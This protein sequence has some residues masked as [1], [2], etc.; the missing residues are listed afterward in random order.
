M[1]NNNLQSTPNPFNDNEIGA[2]LEAQRGG[3]PVSTEAVTAPELITEP[4]SEP[5]AATE[6]AQVEITDE[7]GS[8]W[9]S[10]KTGGKFSKLEDIEIAE[11]NENSKELYAL[12]KEGKVDDVYDY[13][14]K[15]KEDYSKWDTADLLRAKLQKENPTLNKEEIEDIL[16][17]DYK[18]GYVLSEEDK[19]NMTP[20]EVEQ[21]E[22]ESKRSQLKAKADADG[23]R[24]QLEATKK[25]LSLPKITKIEPVID[26][27]P[28]AITEDQIKAAQ[29]DWEAEVEAEMP[30]SKDISFEIEIGEKKDKFSTTFKLEGAQEAAVKQALKTTFEAGDEKLSFQELVSKNAFKLYGKQILAAAVKDAVAKA[31]ELFVEK[32]LKQI[33]LAPGYKGGQ[34]PNDVN[35]AVHMMNQ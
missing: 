13:I 30:K 21:F 22:K 1:E 10:K 8:Q 31:Q 11:L 26:V 29:A 3:E 2:Y 5:A 35:L 15:A 19:E 27:D 24:S 25:E 7:L 17:H 14:I 34:N 12:L 28:N 18:I 32:E 33:D 20:R 23:M 6:P 16:V 4:A 9:L